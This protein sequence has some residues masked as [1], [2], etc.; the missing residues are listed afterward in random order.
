MGSSPRERVSAFIRYKGLTGVRLVVAVSGGPDSVCLLHILA[1]LKDELCLSLHIAHLDHQLRAESASDACYV[2]SLAASLDIPATLGRTDVQAFHLEKKLSLEEAARI[3]RYEFLGEVSEE[4]G[5]EYIAIGHTQDDHLETILLHIIRGTGTRG[6][7]GLKPLTPWTVEGHPITL[8]RPML[9]ITRRETEDYCQQ[10]GLS[11]RL[12]ETNLSQAPLRNKIRLKLLPLL[13]SYN[14]GIGDA[15]LR[16][17]RNAREEHEYLDNQTL[18]F[19]DR[20]VQ[21]QG[22]I[23]R[24]D[25]EVLLSLPPV[26]QRYLLRR[27]IE[28]LLGTLKDIESRH[29]EEIMSA[30]SLATGQHI[31]LPY[32]LVFSVDYDNYWL[33]RAEDVPN[34]FPHFTGTY[35]L[36]VPGTTDVPGWLVNAVFVQ[37]SS[38]QGVNG[39]AVDLDA[40]KTGQGLIVRTRQP[41]DR[42]QP[43]GMASIKKLGEFMVDAKI[44]RRWRADIPV[45]ASKEQIIWLVGYRPDERVKVTPET[46]R[47]L[48]LEFKQR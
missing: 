13:Q 15:L 43:L 2:K 39:L 41:A 35:H 44:P 42:F 34:P 46:K 17:S 28:R 12:D 22:D 27:A 3:K 6:L 11:P 38:G 47:V 36:N 33:G 40:E 23:I 29:I 31:D 16:L 14:T 30:L 9:D 48:R 25:K 21:K 8:V 10:L 4:F 32:G 24:L 45:V 5:T 7:V 37:G 1:N 20:V 26:L 19:W 18:T